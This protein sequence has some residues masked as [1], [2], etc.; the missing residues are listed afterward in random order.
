MNQIIMY[1]LLITIGIVIG[2]YRREYL[3]YLLY[4]LFPFFEI[5][6]IK[7]INLTFSD[8]MIFMCAVP[9]AIYLVLY[10]IPFRNRNSFHI[11]GLVII[12]IL[13]LL[14]LGNR[15]FVSL[16]PT[17]IYFL[18]CLAM[19]LLTFLY[20]LVY[21]HKI[22]TPVLQRI[23]GLIIIVEFALVYLQTFK[24]L[25]IN[26]MVFFIGPTAVNSSLMSVSGLVRGTGTFLDP[27]YYALYIGILTA[28]LLSSTNR[29]VIKMLY[30]LGLAGTLFSLS[31]MG[32][33]ICLILLFWY[34]IKKIQFNS[35][36]QVGKIC[37]WL[38]GF[39][40]FGTYLA[41]NYTKIPMASIMVER[42]QYNNGN[43]GDAEGTRDYILKFYYHYLL[44]ASDPL[45]IAIGRGLENF[46]YL[47][48]EKTG[49]YMVA[50]NEYLQIFA[51]IGLV[52][53][54]FIFW[55]IGYLLLKYRKKTKVK[56][57]YYPVIL[58]ML[59]G[60]FFLTCTY[61]LYLYFFAALFFGFRIKE[62]IILKQAL[63]EKEPIVNENQNYLVIN[64]SVPLRP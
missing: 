16:H 36:K 10:L 18:K 38:V 57:P 11:Q 32:V 1:F 35:L 45:E 2:K 59:F 60:F 24:G 54:G 14:Y 26:Q 9:L 8:L 50:H 41:T 43:I 64:Q 48:Y 63:Y 29:P 19:G 42:F 7:G 44:Q 62:E 56:N 15:Y 58:L 51:D 52:G 28:S 21:Y 33:I 39:L 23:T 40:L 31:R 3:V 13:F 30:F 6:V 4:V 20:A 22:K 46:E 5:G 25:T 49:V 61:Q 37:L 17:R 12:L 53:Y 34:F 47:L 55:L 27:N